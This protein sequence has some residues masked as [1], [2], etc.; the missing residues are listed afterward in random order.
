MIDR[1]RLRIRV[2]LAFLL[3]TAVLGVTATPAVANE[4]LDINRQPRP[5]T[6]S[7]QFHRCIGYSFDAFIQCAAST[8]TSRDSWWE[9]VKY[10]THLA[11]C[12]IW[13]GV[14]QFA[15]IV[16]LTPIKY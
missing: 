12:Q 16:G 7:E 5:C 1:L 14:D 4:C 11:S 15:C 10:Q 8:D 3:V 9:E 6:D 2:A 13:A